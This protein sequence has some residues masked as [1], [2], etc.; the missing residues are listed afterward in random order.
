MKYKFNKLRVILT[1][2][3]NPNALTKKEKLDYLVE[4]VSKRLCNDRFEGKRLTPQEI[5]YV[6]EN[7]KESVRLLLLERANNHSE[8][9]K[10]L[11][12]IAEKENHRANVAV[13]AASILTMLLLTTTTA[14]ADPPEHANN[15]NENGQGNHN[16]WSD[17]DT[18]TGAVPYSCILWGAAIALG[19]YKLKN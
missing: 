13:Q 11:Q 17:D 18:P 16:G 3:L 4:G 8:Q 12:G 9:A 5:I 2:M 14:F 10:R 7:V 6:A 15:D 19:V 1:K